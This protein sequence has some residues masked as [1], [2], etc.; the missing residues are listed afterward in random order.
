MSDVYLSMVP[1]LRIHLDLVFSYPAGTHSVLVFFLPLLDIK[2]L[3]TSS[4]SIDSLRTVM[5]QTYSYQSEEGQP[6]LAISLE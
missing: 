3:Q 6:A 5:M 1:Y 2:Y 4:E